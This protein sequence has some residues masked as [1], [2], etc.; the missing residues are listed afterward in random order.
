[1]AVDQL[2]KNLEYI[3]YYEEFRKYGAHGVAEYMES[4]LDTFKRFLTGAMTAMAKD[5]KLEKFYKELMSWENCD[6]EDEE[7]AHA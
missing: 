3:P 5:E 1:M 4:E 6:N 7:D 2:M